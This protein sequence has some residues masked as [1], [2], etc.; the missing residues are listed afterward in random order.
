LNHNNQAVL[1]QMVKCNTTD[2]YCM[3]KANNEKSNSWFNYVI[4]YVGW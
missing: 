4:K 3:A 1:F 2:Y